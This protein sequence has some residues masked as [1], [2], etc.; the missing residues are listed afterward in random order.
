[1]KETYFSRDILDFFYLLYK[2]RVK[3]LIVGGEAVIFYGNARLTGDID[4]YYD[5]SDTNITKLFKALKEFWNNR[6]PGIEEKKELS[7]EEM[8][9]QFG[10]PPNR[11]DL[12]NAIESIE[13]NEAWKNRLSYKIDY[14][15]EKIV[16][17]YIGLDDLIKNKKAVKRNKDK[18]DL[19]FLIEVKKKFDAGKKI[20]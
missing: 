3:Y 13:F 6:I 18:D 12:I 7:K 5:L 1:M 8:V 16:I 19:K 9:F 4:F 2:H 11:I 10:I 15:K 14:K 17:Y 20:L